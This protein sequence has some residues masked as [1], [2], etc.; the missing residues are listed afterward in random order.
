M[1]YFGD[2]SL[3]HR[4]V[5][6]ADGIL[7]FFDTQMNSQ[8]LVGAYDP[9]CWAFVD[10]VKGWH[11]SNGIRDMA[12]PPIYKRTG[13]VA[14]ISLLYSWTLQ[15][16]AEMCDFIGRKDTAAEYRRKADALNQAVQTQCFNGEFYVDG[17]GAVET[18]EHTQI[19]AILSGAVSG[20]DAAQL[21]IRTMEHPSMP[22]CSFAMKHYVSKALERTGLYDKYF[23]AMMQPWE[24]MI[25]NNLTTCPE[26]DVSFRSD[27]HG[28]S[29]GSIYEVVACLHGIRPSTPGFKSLQIEPRRALMRSAAA[30]Y[31]YLQVL[32]LCAGVKME[33]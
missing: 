2:A 28:W 5:G 20:E 6:T 3:I 22:R 9:E 24:S 17:P 8:G 32:Y 13:V 7:N 31:D 30:S 15:H 11:G 12:V 23:A 21:M 27:C 19:F 10:W 16:A 1:M 14:Y 33:M 29:A 26:D 25:E 4:Y 18:C